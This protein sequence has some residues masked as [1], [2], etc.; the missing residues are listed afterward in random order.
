MSSE[1]PQP[2]LECKE[3]E[4]IL[5]EMPVY[6][7]PEPSDVCEKIDV[8]R[9]SLQSITVYDVT[10]EELSMIESGIKNNIYF[11]LFIVLLGFSVSL[12]IAW[13]TTDM[14][15]NITKICIFYCFWFMS[16][17]ATIVF[18]ILWLVFKQSVRPI[19]EKIR[20]RYQES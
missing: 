6:E 2:R 1:S 17:F 19:V 8:R 12:Y 9:G 7:S 16:M 15:E 4:D 20:N 18:M 13:L 14:T 10:E 11:N 3:T 5:Q